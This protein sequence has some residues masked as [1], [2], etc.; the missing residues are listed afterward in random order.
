MPH[1]AGRSPAGCRAGH[2]PHR[3]GV[4]RPVIERLE[5]VRSGTVARPGVDSPSD[6]LLVGAVLA[7]DVTAF[8]DLYREHVAAVRAVARAHVSDADTVAEIVQDSFVR[9]LQHMDS[10][11]DGDL[12][13]PWL[14][15]IARHASVDRLRLAQRE[16]SLGDEQA[17]ALVDH[18]AEPDDVAELHELAERVQGCVT[19]LSQRDAT[20]V[21]LVTQFGFTTAQVAAA[22]RVTPG[23]A[24]VIVHR[25]R[26]RLRRALMVELLVQQPRLGCARFRALREADPADAASHLERCPECIDSARS[27]LMPTQR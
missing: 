16:I 11:R 22:L 2:E 4:T 9:A 12:F 14:L 10:L 27:E 7:G 21:A 15:S 13:R 18:G 8:D 24:K 17:D 20:A 3:G 1:L 5:C 19:G 26:R 6:R 25:A 23:A